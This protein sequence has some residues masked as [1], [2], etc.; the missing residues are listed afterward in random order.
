MKYSYIRKIKYSTLLKT[1]V[2][3]IFLFPIIVSAINTNA[4]G[5][6]IRAGEHQEIDVHGI[7]K[8]VINDSDVTTN[9]VII[10]VPTKTAEE[11]SLFRDNKPSYVS[12]ADCTTSVVVVP[13]ESSGTDIYWHYYRSEDTELF[14]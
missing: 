14:W 3:T 8:D 13:T 4:T 5:Y 9:P 7:C 11:W 12:L 6:K 10:F 1:T 2:L